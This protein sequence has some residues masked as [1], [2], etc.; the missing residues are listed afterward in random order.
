[1]DNSLSPEVSQEKLVGDIQE[2]IK[3]ADV[4]LGAAVGGLSQKGKEARAEM[5]VQL[6]GAKA[7]LANLKASAKEKLVAGAKQADET[8]RS[9][10]YQSLAVAFGVG[11]LIGVLAARKE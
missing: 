10:P 4:L 5:D 7:R 3:D 2:V 8:I 6:A 11:L 1:M 9:H